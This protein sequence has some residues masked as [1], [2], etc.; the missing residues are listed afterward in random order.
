MAR[1]QAASADSY[2]AIIT[3]TEP[4][5]T[6]RT[7]IFGPYGTAAAAK[8]MR[9]DRVNSAR[10][11]AKP[12]TTVHGIVQRAVPVWETIEEESN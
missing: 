4:D 8:G 7:E 11:Y 3:R 5:G 10:Y 6:I 9:T 2:R 12:R 1:R